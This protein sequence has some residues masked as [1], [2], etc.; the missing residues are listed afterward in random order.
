M[1]CVFGESVEVGAVNF[2]SLYVCKGLNDEWLLKV[3]SVEIATIV[4]QPFHSEIIHP[5]RLSRSPSSARLPVSV[6]AFC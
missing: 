1:C 4:M 5:P 6:Q 2:I 3:R